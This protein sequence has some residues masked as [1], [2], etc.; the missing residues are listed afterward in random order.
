MLSE[1]EE[2][3][4]S[5]S[6]ATPPPSD[7]SPAVSTHAIPVTT[8]SPVPPS[9]RLSPLGFFADGWVVSVIPRPP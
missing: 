4:V 2:T 6:Q 1:S 5:S 7:V 8:S 9:A 3:G